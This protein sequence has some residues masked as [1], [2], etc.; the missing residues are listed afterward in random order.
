MSAVETKPRLVDGAV[1]SWMLK[2]AERQQPW[3]PWRVGARGIPAP[4]RW[5]QR[6]NPL[7][8]PVPVPVA[9]VQWWRGGASGSPSHQPPDATTAL[10]RFL[11]PY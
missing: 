10:G 1:P 7:A 3:K 4:L 6:L 2:R 11:C 9:A 8:V 5:C